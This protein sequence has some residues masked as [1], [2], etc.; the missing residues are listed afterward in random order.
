MGFFSDRAAIEIHIRDHHSYTN[1]I[2]KIFD[3]QHQL[4]LA[5]LLSVHRVMSPRTAVGRVRE[6]SGAHGDITL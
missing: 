1:I 6:R 5:S 4:V 2:G 3:V